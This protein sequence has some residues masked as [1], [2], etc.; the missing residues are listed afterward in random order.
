ML[1]K[2]CISMRQAPF[3]AEPAERTLRFDRCPPAIRFPVC[4]LVAGLAAYLV[5]AGIIVALA[6]EAMLRFL[7][8]MRTVVLPGTELAEIVILGGGSA[9]AAFFL[10]LSRCAQPA[11][12]A[13]GC[14]IAAALAM[15]SWNGVLD[16]SAGG[17]LT[18]SD[19]LWPMAM[20][21]QSMVHGAVIGL[22]AWSIARIFCRLRLL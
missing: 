4:G 21:G 5:H 2:E 10:I 1:N 9:L 8:A 15:V 14:A 20:A 22:I 3:S 13:L 7:P 11:F 19:P 18:R 16:V 17:F 12:W 6:G